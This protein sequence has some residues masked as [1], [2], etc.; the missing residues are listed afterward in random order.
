MNLFLKNLCALF[1]RGRK[2]TYLPT[3]H[4]LWRACSLKVKYAAHNGRAVGSSPTTPIVMR[5]FLFNSNLSF[6]EKVKPSL[7]L[8][9]QAAQKIG[10]GLSTFGLAGAGVGIGLIFASLIAGISRNPLLKEDLFKTAI[11]GFA[12]TEEIALFALMISFLIL[13]I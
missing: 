10:A 1:L 9:L 3:I 8:L 13:F 7:R 11:L 2:T 12:L 6:R 4:L 5:R